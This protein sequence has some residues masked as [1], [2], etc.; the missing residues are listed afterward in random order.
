MVGA[1]EME[2]SVKAGEGAFSGRSARS[3][4]WPRKWKT[5]IETK[6]YISSTSSFL[7]SNWQLHSS[8]HNI[9]ILLCPMPPD[10]QFHRYLHWPHIAVCYRKIENSQFSVHFANTSAKHSNELWFSGTQFQYHIEIMAAAQQMTSTHDETE[11][12]NL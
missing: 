12:W 5:W 6:Y 8:C 4:L 1:G 7:A 3:F 2:T 11:L 10:R 9:S